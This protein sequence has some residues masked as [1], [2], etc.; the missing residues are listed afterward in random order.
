[1][2][3]IRIKHQWSAEDKE[4]LI[5]ATQT[6]MNCEKQIQWDKVML[7][8]PE[9]TKCQLKTFFFNN[10]KPK[11]DQTAYKQ[12][13]LWDTRNDRT[14]IQLVEQHGKKW[15]AIEKLMSGCQAKQLKLRYFYLEKHQRVTTKAGKSKTSK[16]IKPHL[17]QSVVKKEKETDLD[18][19]QEQLLQ[20]IKRMLEQQQLLAVDEQKEENK[21]ITQ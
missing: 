17:E 20:M 12:N 13:D 3:N 14:L 21:H 4:R 18:Q 11:L 15:A 6:H 19:T 5:A 9:K 16:L 1:M 8:F 7:E 2:Q 10:L